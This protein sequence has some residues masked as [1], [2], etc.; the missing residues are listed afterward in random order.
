MGTWWGKFLVI[1]SSRQAKSCQDLTLQM[2]SSAISSSVSA[3][4]LGV[5]FDNALSMD[6]QISHITRSCI[7]HLRNI[8]S[9]RHLLSDDATA[10]LVHSLVSNR[11]DYCNS[12]LSGLPDCKINRL[13]RV[14]NIAARI[15]TRTPKS[16]HITPVLRELHWLPVQARIVYKILLL[17]YRVFNHT[18]PQYLCD[19]LCPYVPHRSLR[20]GQQLLFSEPRMRLKTFGDRAFCSVAPKEWNSLPYSIRASPS[21]DSFKSNLKTYLFKKSFAAD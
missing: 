6:K 11:L 19:L 16:A 14:Q 18:A 1:A 8:G 20:S 13:Q 3:K 5:L 7:F 12:L 17:A 4:N 10:Q 21:L 15:L 2:G 9:V